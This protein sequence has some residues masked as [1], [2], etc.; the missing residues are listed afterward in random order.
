MSLLRDDV[1][2]VVGLIYG[3]AASDC[4]DYFNC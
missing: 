1:S 2:I 4:V 3:L